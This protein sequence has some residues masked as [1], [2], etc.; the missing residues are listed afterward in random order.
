MLRPGEP[1]QLLAG[2]FAL[3]VAKADE[4]V[5]PHQECAL[6]VRIEEI[7]VIKT[8]DI[9]SACKEL[10]A[11]EVWWR[12]RDSKLLQC[13]MLQHTEAL[14]NHNKTSTIPCKTRHLQR[15]E[16]PQKNKTLTLPEHK[17]DSSLHLKCAVCVHFENVPLDLKLVID[18]WSELPGAIRNAIMAMIQTLKYTIMSDRG[19]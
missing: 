12:R 10:Y 5:M 17:K 3:G 14:H 18:A 16:I 11:I 19:K 8:T 7:P 9:P 15:E 4:T 1:V 2:E 6:C 13:Y